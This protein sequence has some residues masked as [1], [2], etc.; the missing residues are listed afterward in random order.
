MPLT[1]ATLQRKKPATDE[2]LIAADSTQKRSLDAAQQRLSMAKLGGGEEAIKTA[3]EALEKVK[4]EIRK[5]GIA[6]T[7]VA[8][9]RPRWDELLVE[10]RPTEAMQEVDAALPDVERRTFNPATFWPALLA[11]S[12][13]DSKLTPE[14][15][16]KAVFLSKDWTAEEVS[17]LRDK[18]VQV[19]QDSLVIDLGN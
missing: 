6:F 3:E 10:H 16:D 2:V 1:L 8:V 9:G 5:T 13:P 12:V 19:N 15:W 11:E 18:A 17:A 7:L 14:Q 4:A